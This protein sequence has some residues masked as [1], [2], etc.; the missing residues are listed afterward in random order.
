MMWRSLLLLALAIPA[1]AQTPPAPANADW[2]RPFPPFRVV[3]NVY[4]VGTWDLSSWLIVT[5]QGNILINTG[6]ADSVPMILASVEALG[7][8]FSDTK[9]IT[10][11][12]AHYDHAAGLAEIK[13]LTGA[14]MLM[15]KDDVPVVESGGK[16]DFLWGGDASMRFEPVHV[17]QRL[18][19]GDKIALGG[20]EL[21]VH[22][23]PGHTKGAVSFTLT[24]RDGGRDYRVL[25]ANM[26]SINPGVK[27]SGMPNYPDIAQA[28]ARTFHD[29]K[30]MQIDIWLASHAS[31]FH[32][33]EKYKPGDPYDPRRFVDR[34]D[35][36]RQSSTS[37]RSTSTSSRKSAGRSNG[38]AERFMFTPKSVVDSGI[39]EGLEDIRKKCVH[40]PYRTVQAAMKAFQGRT[41]KRS[42]RPKRTTSWLIQLETVPVISLPLPYGHGSETP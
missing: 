40:R 29:Q 30:E 18:R 36:M 25:I 13:R 24:V 7:F 11:T 37:K 5:P 41:L 14:R 1:L 6:L 42:G 3:G 21:T 38:N 28:C 10:A 9:L 33:H 35:F 20:T 31:Q 23:H 2:S 15:E 17:D 26:G 19:D 34:R 8:K 12:H 4:W 32:L 27:V 39:A 16:A 22:H